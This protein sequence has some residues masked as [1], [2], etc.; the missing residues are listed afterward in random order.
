MDLTHPAREVSRRGGAAAIEDEVRNAV[1]AALRGDTFSLLLTTVS[2]DDQRS[3]T[4]L[5]LSGE[6]GPEQLRRVAFGP[7]HDV[8]P[9]LGGP[10][11]LDLAGEVRFAE[12]LEILLEANP[13][14]G[15][16]WEASTPDTALLG[17]AAMTLLPPT[18]LIPHGFVGFSQKTRVTFHPAGNGRASVRLLYRRP[19]ERDRPVTRRITFEAGRLGGRLDL[20]DIRSRIP[21]SAA[22]PAQ[23]LPGGPIMPT[24]AQALP[25]YFSWVD[26]GKVP[27]I[28]F[29]GYVCGSCWAFATVGVME[30]AMLVQS[31][32]EEDLSEQFLVSCN[33][34]SWGCWGG[35]WAHGYHTDWLGWV[36]TESGAVLETNF[37]YSGTGEMCPPDLPHPHR[38]S[39]YFDLATDPPSI[40]QAIYEYG[41]VGT[42]VCV[43]DKFQDYRGGVFSTNESCS[44]SPSGSDGGAVTTGNHAVV[45]VG[46]ND[47]NNTWLLRNS[48]GDWWGENG[49][50]RIV[51]GTSGVG[52]VN[53]YAVYAKPTI[54]SFSPARGSWGTSVSIKG[55]GFVGVERVEFNGGGA[56]HTVESPTSITAVV[57]PYATSGPIAVYTRGAVAY[58]P[59]D[60]EVDL[61]GRPDVRTGAASNVKEWSTTLEASVN[62]NGGPTQGRFLY[63]RFRPPQDATPPVPLGDGTTAVP[64]VQSVSSLTCDSVYYWQGVADN[65]AG[66]SYGAIRTFTTA[67]CP[68]P[69]AETGSASAVGARSATLSGS[70]NPNG[71][72]AYGYFEYGPSTFYGQATSMVSLGQGMEGMAFSLPVS[73]LAC[74]TTYHFRA[75][76]RND[77][78]TSHGGDATFATTDD[79]PAPSVSVG[80]ASV[81]D[82]TTATL[83]VTVSP[84]GSETTAWFEY[85]TTSAYGLTTPSVV[86]PATGSWSLIEGVTS[87]NCSTTYFFR[88]V[89]QNRGGTTYGDGASFTMS[90]CLPPTAT[91][92][93]ASA[94][95]PATATLNGS[96]NPNGIASTAWFEYGTTSAYGL[97]TAVVSVGAGRSPAAVAS[98][99][100]SLA[101][102]TTYHFRVVALSAGG[103]SNGNG[104]GFSTSACPVDAFTIPPCR[105]LDTRGAP[106]PYGG[107]ALV[108]G[109]TRKFVIAGQCGIPASARAVSANVTVTQPT[110]AGH[111]RLF[112]GDAVLPTI[113]T[114]NYGA[115]QTRANSAVVVLGTDGDLAVYVG[116]ATGT[117][118]MILDVNAHFQ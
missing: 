90:A 102:G 32:A 45:L 97:R 23:P 63:G 79:C 87:L 80:W 98:A 41:A 104:M 50:M 21:A 74:D 71:S 100:A 93:A 81:V 49:Y 67:K 12:D 77:G 76:G 26:L 31:P 110:A 84:N 1:N 24:Q 39:T 69:I 43:G 25:S 83:A 72:K 5:R 47:A 8:A 101:C 99:V 33:R 111:L 6:G 38:L 66:E 34:S 44:S 55:T 61:F 53:S 96:V 20:S 16:G 37:P 114:I 48:W 58:S 106:G 19:F 109:Q 18:E 28:R 73:E 94:V 88:G 54:S 59:A 10:I 112:P 105:L 118:H 70:V 11:R 85:G 65:P 91:T 14:T 115:A 86:G 35:G 107:P 29:Q 52:T 27:P 22:G 60:F 51:R 113:S 92:L 89:A 13:S 116:Q 103:K 57:P 75:V 4:S 117:V 82:A 36:Q 30:I 95:G 15:A 9:L 108:A 42:N 78:G 56:L 46:W 62:P 2:L 7:L 40:K 68:P 64:L 17:Q 3:Q